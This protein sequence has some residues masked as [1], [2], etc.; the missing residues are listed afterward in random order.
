VFQEPKHKHEPD[1]P[2][3]YAPHDDEIH[4]ATLRLRGWF[5]R[6]VTHSLRE[7]EFFAAANN[8]GVLKSR[9]A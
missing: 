3:C 4:E 1:C 5:H 8:G 6:Q 2:V 9:V 7:Q